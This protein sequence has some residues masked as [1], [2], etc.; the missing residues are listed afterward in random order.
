MVSAWGKVRLTSERLDLVW[1][2]D[3]ALCSSINLA[4]GETFDRRC[5]NAFS[6]L[7][8]DPAYMLMIGTECGWAPSRF[9][10]A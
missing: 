3:A 1:L 10:L 8:A 4:E 5:V 2:M 6:R 7:S 9:S